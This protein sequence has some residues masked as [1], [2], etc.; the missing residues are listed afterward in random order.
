M[1]MAAARRRSIAAG[2][3][4][5]GGV[6][7]LAA[8]AFHLFAASHIP[9]VLARVLDPK[10]Y[11][12]LEPIVSFTFLLNAVLLIPLALSTLACAAGIRRGAAWPRWIALVNALT[13]LA[14][15]AL[16]AWTMGLRYF[17]DAPLFVA[18]ALSVTAAGLVMLAPLVWAWRD[19]G[20]AAG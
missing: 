2:S 13:V 12:F 8:A 11:G 17:A 9:E 18:G 7:L 15:P 14:L 4:T 1:A 20:A 16:I 5:A 3:L 19:I 10:V 6:F